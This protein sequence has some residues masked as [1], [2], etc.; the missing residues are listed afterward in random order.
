MPTP[1]PS[2][3]PPTDGTQ[4]EI[5]PCT[6]NSAQTW[7]YAQDDSLRIDNKCL[8]IPTLAQ[9]APVDLEP[10]ASAAN[11]QW[12]LVYPRAMNPALGSRQ[13]AL[14]NP[15]SGMCL[16]DPGFSTANKARMALWPCNGY[17]NESW[18]LP[19]GQVMSQIPGLC[20]DDS[21][22]QTADGTKAD[23]FGC[24][25]TAGQTWQAELDGTVRING[26]CLDVA[27]GA[28]TSGS[29]VD[30]FS[31]NGTQA[32]QWRLVSQGAAVTLMNPGSGLCLADP[33]D[34]TNAGTQLVIA[35]CVA[36]DPGMSWR[37]S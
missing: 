23:I 35:T 33:G 10:C 29:P 24:D 1:V 27:R 22:N 18:T 9:G 31:C 14:V 25:G 2:L 13:T 19:P 37:V 34:S 21:G 4:T 32:Q 12:H 6:G 20:L 28:K 17:A 3:P 7:T 30:L 5:R 36:G 16:A 26:K 11:Q 15:R 8:T